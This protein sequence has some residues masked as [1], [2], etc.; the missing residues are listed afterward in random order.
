IHYRLEISSDKNIK[1]IPPAIQDSLK[2]VDILKAGNM[3]YSEQTGKKTATLNFLLSKYDSA[4]VTIPA[5]RVFYRTGKDT[6]SDKGIDTS[7]VSLKSV[8]SNPVNFQV[9]LV[10]VDLKKDIKDVKDPEKIPLDLTEI[11]LWVLA[12]LILLALGFYFY[13]KY[14]KKK[15]RKP[16]IRKEVIIPPHIKA[17]KAL[18][19]LEEEKLWQSGEVKQYHSEITE[20][21]RIYFAARF[22]LQALELTTSETL[23]HLKGRKDADVIIGT[24]E[25]FLTNADLVKFAKFSPLSS[26]NEEMMRQ[27]VEIVEKTKPEEKTKEKTGEANV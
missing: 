19:S 4:D 5:I 10:K 21:I 2:D 16:A 3:V 18:K 17:L 8:L 13:R 1:I 25:N 9:R 23:G 12:G 6:L 24:T 7:D 26:V 15:S 11:I 27:A 20:I 22:G 14:R